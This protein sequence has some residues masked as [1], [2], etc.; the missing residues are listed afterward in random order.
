MSKC[1]ALLHLNRDCRASLACLPLPALRVR[2]AHFLELAW[3]TF[4]HCARSGNVVASGALFIEEMESMTIDDLLR[5]AVERKAS[6]LHLK[7]G[8]YPHVRMDGELVPLTDQPRITGEDMLNMA[9]SM[10]SNRQK[11]KFKECAEIDLAYGAAGLG[12]SASTYFSSAA[13]SASFSASFPPRFALW[14]SSF[15]RRSPSESAKKRAAWC[16]SPASPVRVS[17]PPLRP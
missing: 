7:V 4:V 2:P 15:F 12:A 1:S 3:V 14:R 10:M 6:D 8:N 5:I 13:M 17:P 11:Q 16:W 9:F